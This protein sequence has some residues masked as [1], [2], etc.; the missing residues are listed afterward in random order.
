LRALSS[1]IWWAS[2]SAFVAPEVMPGLVLDD[3][4]AGLFELRRQPVL[5][6]PRVLDQM[7]IDRDDLH[8]VLQGHRESL[9]LSVAY[10][11]ALGS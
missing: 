11:L 7:I 9:S 2:S 6:Y 3:R 1:T 5:P 10:L 8:G 4:R